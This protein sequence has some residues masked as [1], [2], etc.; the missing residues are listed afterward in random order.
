MTEIEINKTRDLAI[1]ESKKFEEMIEAIGKET[2]VSL[3][4]A[5]PEA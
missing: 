3:A 1:I 5:G 2:M 4:N